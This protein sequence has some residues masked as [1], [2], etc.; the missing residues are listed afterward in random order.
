MYSFRRGQRPLKFSKKAVLKRAQCQR[1]EIKRSKRSRRTRG[2][3]TSRLEKKAQTGQEKK[4]G[5]RSS[6]TQLTCCKTLTVVLLLK[7]FDPLRFLSSLSTFRWVVPAGG[8]V[9]LRIWFY[10]ETPGKFEQNFKFE[11]VG[12]RRLYQLSCRGLCCFPSICKDYMWVFDSRM[13]KTIKV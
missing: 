9:A 1:I 6:Q 12:T 13:I 5:K 10:S 7:F 11:L 4:E 3:I 8:E 2:W